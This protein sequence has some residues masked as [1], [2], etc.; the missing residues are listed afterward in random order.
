MEE[1]EDWCDLL[2]V[3][4]VPHI[5]LA[6]DPSSTL[7][8]EG[9]VPH[10]GKHGI[11]DLLCKQIKNIK[12]ILNR[13]D[14][15]HYR[16]IYHV[17]KSFLNSESAFV[18]LEL[19]PQPYV[20]YNVSEDRENHNSPLKYAIYT[21]NSEI[22]KENI[23]EVNGNIKV[24]PDNIFDSN[25]HTKIDCKNHKLET[26]ASF[27]I[28]TYLPVQVFYTLLLVPFGNGFPRIL[29]CKNVITF[30]DSCNFGRVVNRLA[31]EDTYLEKIEFQ[32]NAWTILNSANS[33]SADYYE[34]DAFVNLPESLTGFV[35]ENARKFWT[36][37]LHYYI[38]HFSG[39]P[40]GDPNFGENEYNR[41]YESSLESVNEKV[42]WN[43]ET[44]FLN[45][46]FGA[47]VQEIFDW[48]KDI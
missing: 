21:L 18:K 31:Q 4:A 45:K 19:M 35:S 48:V 1:D 25:V 12:D 11:P 14:K 15:V 16:T 41:L 8:I 9:I 2:K 30:N 17:G 33:R 22:A 6:G 38:W 27:E 3:Q 7:Q 42:R 29:I 34:T 47:L 40:K 32:S 26:N 39:R 37:R 20:F 43:L 44:E 28:S 13:A 24:N 46:C 23:K 10:I 5:F 36:G